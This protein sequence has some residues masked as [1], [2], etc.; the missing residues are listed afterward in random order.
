MMTLRLRPVRWTPCRHLRI[1]T[2]VTVSCIVPLA[3]MPSAFAW[4]PTISMPST[5]GIRSFHTP[6]FTVFGSAVPAWVPTNLNAGP[7]PAITS[8][9]PSPL[10]AM[11]PVL[12]RS[13]VIV[14]VRR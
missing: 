7:S 12:V 4:S 13:T 9:A 10:I 1:S 14:L 8:R 2:R 5:V 11:G 3:S 6:G